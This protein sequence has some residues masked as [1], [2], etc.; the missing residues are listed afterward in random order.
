M[1]K[2]PKLYQR[3]NDI[4]YTDTTSQNYL[5][6]NE[7]EWMTVEKILKHPQSIVAD[8]PLIKFAFNGRGDSW[9]WKWDDKNEPGVC[10][11]ETVEDYGTYYANNTSDAI[12]RQII[13]Y[14]A[15]ANFGYSFISQEEYIKA[16]NQ[17]KEQLRSWKNMLSAFLP[18]RHICTIDSLIEKPLRLHSCR[19]GDWYSLLSQQEMNRYIFDCVG[20]DCINQQFPVNRIE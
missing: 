13:E 10:F 18:H 5:W 16:D 11:C 12:L 7:I 14:C 4:G 2:I 19:F 17:L 20:F 6:L 9:C 15:S 3:M 1:N 8:I